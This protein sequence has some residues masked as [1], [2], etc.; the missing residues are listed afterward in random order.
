MTG[1][2]IVEANRLLQDVERATE[3]ARNAI[4]SLEKDGEPDWN[5]PFF[6]DALGALREATHD[7]SHAALSLNGRVR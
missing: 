6:A 4:D 2:D 3:R 1:M 5:D 7:L